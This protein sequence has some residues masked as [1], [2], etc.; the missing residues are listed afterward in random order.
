MAKRGQKHPKRFSSSDTTATKPDSSRL[1]LSP[2]GKQSKALYSVD[3]V[4]SKLEKAKQ[5]SESKLLELLLLL[6]AQCR[7]FG[8]LGTLFGG[9]HVRDKSALSLPPLH[10]TRGVVVLVAAAASSVWVCLQSAAGRD[11]GG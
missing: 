4:Q 1:C 6:R 5:E 7:F 8:L 9:R 10:F 2:S 11:C 3:D